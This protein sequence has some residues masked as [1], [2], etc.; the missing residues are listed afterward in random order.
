MSLDNILYINSPSE[1]WVYTPEVTT[2]LPGQSDC[3]S[4]IPLYSLYSHTLLE[5]EGTD[6]TLL[7]YEKLKAREGRKITGYDNLLSSLKSF[8]Y[9]TQKYV[10]R[11]AG[12]T[13]SVSSNLGYLMDEQDN[14]L[15]CVCISTEKV[16]QHK[17][18]IFQ[19]I[20]PEDL[21]IVINKDFIYGS[22]Y[23][24]LYKKMNSEIILPLVELSS[25]VVISANPDK[26]MFKSNFIPPSFTNVLEFQKHLTEEAPK[27]ILF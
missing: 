7:Q 2:G 6:V 20:Q 19:E 9:N 13:H 14:I 3:N 21:S 16:L 15:M 18:N 1:G 23:T 22:T 26:W 8:R 5:F 17:E 12:N 24:N 25:D 27:L 4:I 10:F 11:K